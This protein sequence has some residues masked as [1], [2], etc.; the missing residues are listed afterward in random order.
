M[1]GDELLHA[2]AISRRSG[3]DAGDLRQKRIARPWLIERQQ[4][5]SQPQRRTRG[6]EPQ[7][8]PPCTPRR[9]IATTQQY[10]AKHAISQQNV[11]LVEQD[12][13][14]QPYDHERKATAPQAHDRIRTLDACAVDLQHKAVTKQE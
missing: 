14:Q 2:A 11:T 8:H 1:L 9:P 4:A 3:L 7:R 13:V 6:D 5:D 12:C 10:E